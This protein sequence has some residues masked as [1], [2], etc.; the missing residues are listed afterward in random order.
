MNNY[1]KFRLHRLNYSKHIF[2]I[3]SLQ[4]SIVLVQFH[5]NI[6]IEDIITWICD[7]GIIWSY[8]FDLILFFTPIMLFACKL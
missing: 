2:L 3:R 8:T 1:E 5:V 7:A 6:A 4:Q